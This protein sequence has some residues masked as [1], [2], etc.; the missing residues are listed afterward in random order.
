MTLTAPPSG[1]LERLL[2]TAGRILDSRIIIP[3]VIS[4]LS[5]RKNYWARFESELTRRTAD[6]ELRHQAELQASAVPNANLTAASQTTCQNSLI[7]G[8]RI[9][10]KNQELET[11]LSK[12]ARVGRPEE[13]DFDDEARTWAGIAVSEKLGRKKLVLRPGLAIN[14]PVVWDEV[15]IAQHLCAAG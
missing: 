1:S 13:M 12:L 11:K 6:S 10:D 3:H 8:T 2:P 15:F 9:R 5:T 4:F 14:N 7:L